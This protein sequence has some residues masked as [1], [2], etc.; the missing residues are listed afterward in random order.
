MKLFAHRISICLL[1]ALLQT[2]MTC[3]QDIS[4]SSK[5]DG[6]KTVFNRTT[7]GSSFNVEVR[8]RIDLTDDDKDIK[9]MSPDGYLEITKT[10]F[11][12]KRSLVISPQG[13]GGLKRQYY[14]G[15]TELPFEPDGRKWMNE[16]LPELVRT[17]TIGAES[18]VN[19]F[20][21]QGG[22]SAVLGEINLLESDYVKAHYANVLMDLKPSQNDYASIVSRVTSTIESD[23]YLS[24]FLKNNLSRFLSTKEAKE[25]VFAAT[26]K[27][28]SDHYKTEVIKASIN[29][30]TGPLSTENI[31]SILDASG[32]M[33]SDHYK[34]EVFSA[35]LRQNNLTDAVIAEMISGTQSIESDYYKSVVL[36]KALSKSGLSAA[37]YQK[38]LES[39]KDIESDH[40]KTE[41]LTNLL[42][43]KL[44]SAQIQTLVE[45]STSIGSDHYTSVVFD[46][47]LN[48]EMTDEAFKMV[49]DRAS[50]VES[51]Y[52]AASILQAALN[53][54]DLSSAKVLSIINAAG[55][56][57]S[58]HYLTEVLTQAAPK[59]RNGDAALKD[60]YRAVAKKIDSETYYGRAIKA[61][62]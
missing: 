45:I 62:D 48:Q 51:D 1:A 38:I 37:S 10:V 35:L 3:G 19:R 12:S 47:V 43:N 9:S 33:Q 40:Y 52:Y 20:Y 13:G 21:K 22:S 36:N 4:I 6:K 30:E 17:T 41:V 14:E 27:I 26:N 42:K 50:H 53:H 39:V 18:R 60:A 2:G 15:R 23:Y 59:V 24:E 32:K 31:R 11:G 44:S 25:A 28:E 49:I 55:N 46:E 57:N 34:T 61:I 29:E 16:I 56:I 5:S 58:D 8:G 54:P 7:V